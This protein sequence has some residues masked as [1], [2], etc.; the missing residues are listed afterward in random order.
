MRIEFTSRIKRLGFGL[1]IAE[2]CYTK[3][4]VMSECGL[5]PDSVIQLVYY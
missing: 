1:N 5:L 2:C 3:R 4:L